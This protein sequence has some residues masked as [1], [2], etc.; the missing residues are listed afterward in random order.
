MG[1][2]R[3]GVVALA[4]AGLLAGMLGTGGAA[5]AAPAD[6]SEDV[7]A[8]WTA[9]R[10]AAAQPRDLVL[11]ERGLAYLQAADGS[12][13]P[14]GHATPARATLRAEPTP[15]AAPAARAKPTPD[16]VPPTVADLVRCSTT[17]STGDPAQR[18]SATVTDDQGLRSVAVIVVYPDGRTQSFTP[19]QSGDTWSIVISG[20]AGSGWGWAVEA[21][22]TGPKGGNATTESGATFAAG[23]GPACDG[24]GDP[25]DPPP[26]PPPPGD[27]VSDAAYAESGTV[28]DLVGRIFFEMPANRRGTRWNGYVCSGTFVADGVAGRSVV[29]TA[30]HCVYDDVNKVFARNVVFIPDLDGTWSST[31]AAL[32]G[33]TE[34]T[35]CHAADFG[36]V[37]D[38]WTRHRFPDNIPFDYAFYALTG[39]AAGDGSTF[40]VASQSE[41][42]LVVGDDTWGIGYP[43]DQDPDLRYCRE[44][45]STQPGTYA[46]WSGT[47]ANWWLGSCA[48]T[49]GSSGGPWLEDTDATPDGVDDETLVVSV[50]SWGYTTSDGMA[51][52]RLDLAPT[53]GLL[54][55]ARTQGPNAARGYVFTP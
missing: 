26:P 39:T 29:V 41:G 22:D 55:L 44:G 35:T 49:G 21:K 42:G 9:E 34:G 5:G 52:P 54:D 19:G 2:R 18:F 10:L 53:T 3:T 31:N 15:T 47:Y 30:A 1:A 37:H 27:V 32:S 33:C 28:N 43:Y 13:T 11:D 48:M 51:G 40:A 45:V 25:G 24:G 17:T 23:D 14:H 38:Q 50:N 46:S 36:V 8:H 12:L 4:A 16:D 20:F 6:R 7:R